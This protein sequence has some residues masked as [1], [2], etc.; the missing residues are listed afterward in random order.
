[1]DETVWS[2]IVVEAERQGLASILYQRLEPG[3]ASHRP[4]PVPWQ[5]LCTAVRRTAAEG[6]AFL[7]EFTVVMRAC[8]ERGLD[9]M[10]LRGL[11][12]AAHLKGDL[13]IRPMHDLDFL[14]RREDLPAMADMLGGLGYQ[15]IDRRPGFAR[16]FSYTLEFVKQGNRWPLIEPHWT[17]A[18]PPF[19]DRI[20]M[21]K[22][23]QRRRRGRVAGLDVSLLSPADFLLHLCFHLVHKGEDAP[24][25]WWYELHH[26]IRQEATSLDWPE[27]V[28]V[29]HQSGQRLMVAGVLR[30][31]RELFDSRVPDSVL[32]LLAETQPAGC[33][34]LP[35]PVLEGRV[36]RLLTRSRVDGRETLAQL[37]TIKG[38]RAR[39]RFAGA[40][41]FPSAAFMRVHYGLSSRSELAGW[42]V[43]RALVLI[44]DGAKGL[45]GLILPPSSCSG[46][47]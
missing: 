34:A 11:A 3:G 37:L 17:T 38:V 4:P 2:Q 8:Q 6:L 7:R 36:V 26:L 5:Q 20:D 32:T 22:V 1:M 16:T 27:V 19:A 18:Y 25:L 13:A 28:L 35:Q 47:Y 45:A 31:L 43:K 29:A 44:R 41:L 21:A 33:P 30:R 14:V 10:P 39:L 23:W 12:L 40:L 46:S 24:L 9:C 42:Y 15:E